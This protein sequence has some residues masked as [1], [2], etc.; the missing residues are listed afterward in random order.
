MPESS[1]SDATPRR[2]VRHR[3]FRAAAVAGTCCL[4]ALLAACGAS[5]A[6]QGA[7][8]SSA[9]ALTLEC[10]Q[11][12]AVL[13]DGPGPTVDPIGYAEAQILPLRKVHPEDK[14]LEEAIESLDRAYEE[15]YATSDSAAAKNAE[16]KESRRMNAICPGA[17]P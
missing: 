8:K 5:G 17:A 2:T 9:S 15:V 11:V 14:A 16:N 13:S 1:L 6:P 12:S 7:S 4:A 3:G 10:L